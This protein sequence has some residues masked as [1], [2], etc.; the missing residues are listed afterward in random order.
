MLLR[1]SHTNGATWSTPA[2]VL[3]DPYNRSQFDATLT[4]LP[5]P[6]PCFSC[7]SSQTQR[8]TAAHVF[9]LCAYP[10]TLADRGLHQPP[11]PMTMKRAA[12]AS[13][14]ESCSRGAPQRARARPAAPR[15]LSYLRRAYE[16]LQFDQRRQRRKL[17]ERC[18]A[19]AW[20]VRVP[21]GRDGEWQRV[22]NL[23]E[24]R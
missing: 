5:A 7:T 14:L 13:L 10:Q 6:M 15:L 8:S 17:P 11:S 23:S 18:E 22:D 9:R 4:Y 16:Q 21:N 12:L 2:V 20:L 24:R 19:A 1:S 3:S